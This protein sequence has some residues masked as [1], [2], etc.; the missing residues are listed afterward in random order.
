MCLWDMDGPGP[1]PKQLV[2]GGSLDLTIPDASHLAYLDDDGWHGI[3]GAPFTAT[4]YAMTVYKAPGQTHEDLYIGTRGQGVYRYDGINWSTIVSGTAYEFQVTDLDGAGPE[5]AKL[6]IGTFQGVVS[7]D[8]TTAT[9]LTGGAN[10]TTCKAIF[11]WDPDG[12][13]PQTP[14]I[15]VGQGI[16]IKKWDGH[17]WTVFTTTYRASSPG[18][19][20]T[21]RI[22]SFDF[23]G[24]GPNPPELVIAGGFGE[25]G[26]TSNH[27]GPIAVYRNGT[28]VG[29]GINDGVVN[30]F[31]TFDPDGAGPM[32]PWLVAT[33][34]FT[35]AGGAAG[36]KIAHLTD[37]A[38]SQFP[39]QWSSEGIVL[40][41]AN[42]AP[43]SDSPQL[44]VGGGFQSRPVFAR[45]ALS[46][47]PS[48]VASN[49]NNVSRPAGATARVGVIP[50]GD[51]LTFRWYKGDVALNDGVTAAGSTLAGVYGARLTISNLTAADVGQYKVQIGNAFGVV[52]ST[53]ATVAIGCAAD[54]NADNGIDFF[55]YLDFVDA[56]SLRRPNADFNGDDSIDL[57]D[58]LDF[59]D[60]FSTGC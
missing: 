35:L 46:G 60:A 42:D 18:T 37:G 8:G 43:F 33:G 12:D 3:P 25:V 17:T 32:Q 50:S 19:N 13:G 58:Y 16:L 4:V 56:F 59:V 11:A 39:P 15:Y 34:N 38:W 40:L 30:D 1:R 36:T 21:Q 29:V 55:D 24:D 14:V 26:T 9:T 5:P 52:T 31:E 49:P 20:A 45:F 10:P 23:D 57:F 28:F 2:V 6:Y 44:N 47:G 54:F 22:S 48:G 51:E 7:Y 27:T 41:V 53:Y